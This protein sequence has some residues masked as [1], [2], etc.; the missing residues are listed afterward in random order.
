MRRTTS[1]FPRTRSHSPSS[2]P[3]TARRSPYKRTH[4]RATARRTKP[5]CRQSDRSRIRH[6]GSSAFARS[7]QT[8][9]SS[10]WSRSR[11]P[12]RTR[13]PADSACASPAWCIRSPAWTTTRTCI[14]S[15]TR[16][17]AADERV[18]GGLTLHRWAQWISANCPRGV[19]DGEFGKVADSPT[20]FRPLCSITSSMPAIAAGAI[21][22]LLFEEWQTAECACRVSEALARHGQT[23]P[24]A[25]RLEREPLLR[26][27]AHRLAAADVGGH[28]HDG[29][30]AH[31]QHR[32]RRAAPMRASFLTAFRI[33]AF[34]PV[35]RRDVA[36]VRSAFGSRPAPACSSRWRVGNVRRGGRRRSMRSRICA[37]ASGRMVLDGAQRR[38]D[39]RRRR[40]RARR[41][42]A[43]A[44]SRRSTA[45]ARS[46]VG[47]ARRVRAGRRGRRIFRFGVSASLAR[48]L[49]A[50]SD[51]VLANSVSEPFGLVGLEAMAAG[52]VAFTGGTGEDYA[53]GG[54]NAVVLET[55]DP[56]R[57]RSALGRARVV[58]RND[59]P[60]AS[61]GAKDGSR[62]RVALGDR[63]SHRRPRA[64]GAKA[65][66]HLG[67][68]RAVARRRDGFDRAAYA[69]SDGASGSSRVSG[70]GGRRIR[71][72][73]SD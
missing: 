15:A 13:K 51:G 26:L 42:A 58:A 24:R 39:R 52:G 67:V 45:R 25:L 41:V 10:Q 50:A 1:L 14:S 32:T 9:W 28:D 64:A 30:P 68:R 73:A 4:R 40:A 72:E 31:A 62:L 55:L 34:E 11:D 66:A 33:R 71:Y 35:A 69:R 65:R 20:R 60:P 49:Y 19:Y 63:D 56:E 21:P 53:I 37:T 48:T 36:A 29:Q 18:G 17:C 12:T 27:R 7:I 57:D 23:R 70:A 59:D 5:L 8:A 6:D 16:R 47:S 46:S 2:L 44:R 22:I 3:A 54:R 43:R 38:S 61:R